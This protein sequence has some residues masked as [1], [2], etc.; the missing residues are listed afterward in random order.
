MAIWIITTGSSD[1]QLHE[2]AVNHWDELCEKLLEEED[3]LISS[4]ES[5]IL[6]LPEAVND[7]ISI[8]ARFLGWVYSRFLEHYEDLAFPL[9]NT[10]CEGFDEKNP[11]PTHA[12]VLLTDQSEL[13][14]DDD[15][16]SQDC[17][18]RQDT[19][20]LEEILTHYFQTLEAEKKIQIQPYFATIKPQNGKGIDN[21]NEMLD[22]VDRALEEGLQKLKSDVEIDLTEDK[23]YVSHQAGTPAISSAVQFLTIS[24]FGNV[25]FLVSDRFYQDGE[26]KSAPE[27]LDSSKYWRGL[28]IQKA[29]KLI[30]DGLPG[31]ALALL[32]NIEIDKNIK[33]NLEALVE[34][35]N[36]KPTVDKQEEFEPKNAVDRIRRN[37]DLIEIFFEQE[38]YIPGI[39]LLAAAQETYMK[40]AIVHCLKKLNRQVAGIDVSEFVRWDN[41][42]LSLKFN[43]TNKQKVLEFQKSE[44]LDVELSEQLKFPVP[45]KNNKKECKFFWGMKIIKEFEGK[46]HLVY[47]G[48]YIKEG[49]HNQGFYLKSINVYKYFNIDNSRALKW[50]KKLGD[51]IEVSW[52]LLNWIGIYD[53]DRE[54]DFRNQLMHNL[55][56]VEKK[57]VMDY[58]YG[59]SEKT[60]EVDDS[61]SVKIAYQEQVKQPFVRAL[62]KLGLLPDTDLGENY[63]KQ[64]LAELAREL[65]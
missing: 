30:L 9:L 47:D 19:C 7:L 49:L 4:Y 37:L 5:D 38:N 32:E 26:L 25:K 1:V 65:E 58:L 62:N 27:I 52:P 43:D 31:S 50:L 39:A 40:A 57:D 54:Q 11:A 13:F 10:F 46:L 44:S 22:N 51:G 14:S 64:E 45:E 8:P 59:H 60:N 53:R 28:Q 24:K 34:E 33:S 15:K 63:L 42:G 16:L 56:G 36:I 6:E 29:K 35:F 2:N 48:G 21:W 61:L 17:P 41:S 12:I 23:I 20:E 18:F 3:S 55:R